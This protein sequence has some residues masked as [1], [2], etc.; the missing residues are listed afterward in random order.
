M[1]YVLS[2]IFER[3]F[4][5]DF[6]GTFKE[7]GHFGKTGGIPDFFSKWTSFMEDL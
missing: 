5:A 6:R 4:R 7:F 2:K 1:K 3:N